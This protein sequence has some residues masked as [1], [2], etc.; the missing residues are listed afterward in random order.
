MQQQYSEG[1]KQN[2]IKRLCTP[3]GPTAASLAL[4]IGVSDA[5]ISC[6][7]HRLLAPTALE[8]STMTA[9]TRPH[10]RCCACSWRLVA[11]MMRL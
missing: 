2:I 4:E 10:D 5:T 7:K 9:A 11:S 6:W 8:T 3:G 1:F